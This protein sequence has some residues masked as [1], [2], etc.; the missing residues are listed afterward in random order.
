MYKISDMIEDFSFSFGAGGWESK[1]TFFLIS[2]KNLNK[3]KG[4]NKFHENTN[5]FV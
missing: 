3:V 2:R 4:W 5:V 1:S